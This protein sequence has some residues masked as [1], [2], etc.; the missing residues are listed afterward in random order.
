VL[1]PYTPGAPASTNKFLAYVF[2]WTNQ[3]S[4]NHV[5]NAIATDT[6]GNAFRSVPVP[7]FVGNVSNVTPTVTITQPPNGATFSAPTNIEFDVSIYDPSGEVD[8]VSFVALPAPGLSPI[9]YV[10]YLG[11]V[12]NWTSL[13]PSTRNF[14][15][16]WSN[17]I[18]GTWSVQAGARGSDGAVVGSTSVLI[19]V[20]KTYLL[21]VDIANPTNGTTYP[22]P[23]NIELIAGVV[24]NN[25]TAAYV[26]FFDGLLPLGVASNWVVVDPPGS[27]G[28]PAGSHAYFFDW[29]NQS[30]GCHVLTATV[31]DTNGITFRSEPV[32]VFIGSPSN[33]PPLVRITSPPNM[34]SFNAPVNVPL[35]AFAQAPFGGVQSVEFFAGTNSLG[36]GQSLPVAVPLPVPG[37]IPGPVSGPI[38]VSNFFGS[39]IFVLIWSN[40]PPGAYTLTALAT[41]NDGGSATSAPV[42]ITIEPALPPP[43]NQLDVV[44]IV[45]TDPI[46]IAS[47]NCWPWLGG[48]LTWS[49]WGSPTAIWTWQTNCGPIDASF[50]V[51]R[52]GSTN[53]ELTVDYS[54]SGTATNGIDYAALPGTVTIP[55]GQCEAAIP[56]LPLA[57]SI[58]NFASTVILTLIG[59]TNEP[60]EY[61]MGFPSSA[62]AIIID[63][64]AP[65]PLAGGTLL[66]DRS[67]H[68]WMNGPDGAWFHI[69]YTTNLAD[70]TPICTNQ[71]V[72]GS[73]DFIDPGAGNSTARMY[74]AVPI[75][76]P[77]RD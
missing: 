44:S 73:I 75:S 15:F 8:A 57:S 35:V 11:S 3:T 19:T 42:N 14:T 30:L 51:R 58:S 53:S 22:A 24:A 62:E 21:S 12:T 25:D 32:T 41:D 43:T 68:M 18:A 34:A 31:T 56:I 33:F 71:V 45:A 37:P 70:W 64:L 48:P 55:A 60:P 1:P 17:A 59:T 61:T 6:N 47:T 28:L 63:N 5:I 16:V 13:D 76:G 2:D 65:Q 20:E 36:F 67:F 9:I 49:N 39:N 72:Y 52:F 74:R 50:T 7:I 10:I 66:P 38:I 23:T 69:D 4:G 29:T 46:A 27:P 77:P 54:V 26:E 40:A